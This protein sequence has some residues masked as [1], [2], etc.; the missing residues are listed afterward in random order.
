MLKGAVAGRYAEA[1]YDIA[2]RDNA[3]DRIE[4]ELKSL[5]VILKESEDLQKVLFHPQITADDKKELLEKVFS[6]K[7]SPVTANFLALL[8]DRRR[9]T[10]F[11][12]ITAEFVK[13]ANEGRNTVTA[14]VTSAVELNDAEKAGM[15]KTL[16]KMTGKTVQVSYSVDPSLVGGVVVRIGD[17][18][19]D[20]SVKTRL[21]DMRERLKAIS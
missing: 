13:R 19:I 14:S 10:F 9:E 6:G 5:E 8:V 11:G 2:V 1:L 20:G 3:V 16:A 12:D 17:K 21:C 15:D 18:I 4:Q 7:I